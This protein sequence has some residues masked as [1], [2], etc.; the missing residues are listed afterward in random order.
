MAA[1]RSQIGIYWTRFSR[2]SSTDTDFSVILR[3]LIE[4]FE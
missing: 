4:T 3:V 2:D 1:D